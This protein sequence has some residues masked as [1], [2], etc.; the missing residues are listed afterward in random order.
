MPKDPADELGLTLV[1]A[2]SADVVPVLEKEAANWW[3]TE[4]SGTIIDLSTATT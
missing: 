3:S 1:L 4:D 2:K